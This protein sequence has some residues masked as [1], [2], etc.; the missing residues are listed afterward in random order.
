MNQF[1]KSLEGRRV[2]LFD[3]P[4]EKETLERLHFRSWETLQKFGPLVRY[5]PCLSGDGIK[6]LE[7]SILLGILGEGF[8]PV[9]R[10]LTPVDRWS[11][12]IVVWPSVFL[13]LVFVKQ[14]N[15]CDIG[16]VNYCVRI[17]RWIS[18]GGLWISTVLRVIFILLSVL[19]HSLIRVSKFGHD[20]I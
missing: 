15:S 1:P 17:K 8:S 7:T 20:M 5:N 19:G 6:S 4:R 9:S 3:D 13:T 2:D 16:R 10:G 12:E 14:K 18:L 11:P